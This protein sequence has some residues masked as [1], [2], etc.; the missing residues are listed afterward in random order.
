MAGEKI[1]EY[2]D[3]TVSASGLGHT[4]QRIPE[5]SEETGQNSETP[6]PSSS[7]LQRYRASLHKAWKWQPRPARY[8]PENPP[9]FTLWLNIMFSFVRLVAV[10]R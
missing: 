8:D 10:P 6:R 7:R 5:P 3:V 1:A 9:K 4:G 2:R